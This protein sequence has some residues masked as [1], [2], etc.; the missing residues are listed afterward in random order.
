MNLEIMRI[1]LMITILRQSRPIRV[2]DA[3]EFN[4]IRRWRYFSV[5]EELKIN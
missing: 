5:N 3:Y 4:L 1:L 2:T